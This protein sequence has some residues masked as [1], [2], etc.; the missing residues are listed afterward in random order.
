MRRRYMPSYDI[1]SDKR[2]TQVFELLAAYGDHVQYSVFLADM[3]D[4]EFVVLRGKLLDVIHEREDQVLIVDL[5]RETRSLEN[6]LEVVGRPYHPPAR[7]M[8]V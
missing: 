6:T 5:G 8:V 2:R 4:R 3:S 7:T 1:A